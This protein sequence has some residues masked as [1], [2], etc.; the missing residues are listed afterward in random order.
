LRGRL[1]LAQFLIG[2]PLA[3]FPVGINLASE[4]LSAF[5]LMTH[6]SGFVGRQEARLSLAFHGVGEAEV[7]AVAGLGILRARASRFAAFDEAFRD[8]TA[9]QGDRF[10]ER[11]RD[12]RSRVRH[13]TIL[14]H[15][16]P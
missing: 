13:G 10:S 4:P 11:K 15:H 14:R 3:V 1:N 8:G 6:N 5:N 12:G 2:F 7:R 16:L 9:A